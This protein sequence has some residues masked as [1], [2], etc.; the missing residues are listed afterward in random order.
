MSIHTVTEEITV[1]SEVEILAPP[2]EATETVTKLACREVERVC[3]KVE[4]EFLDT[5][6]IYI[7]HPVY[8]E[9]RK[10][11]VSITAIFRSTVIVNLED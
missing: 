4:L 11:L 10:W 1:T 6:D 9:G 5:T 7:G 2:G 3:K 8:Q